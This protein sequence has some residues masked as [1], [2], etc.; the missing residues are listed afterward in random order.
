[1]NQ[2]TCLRS[3]NARQPV[4]VTVDALWLPS[5]Q[6]FAF[7]LF[8]LV[9]RY[10][11]GGNPNYT[12]DYLGPLSNC[13]DFSGSLPGLAE[14]LVYDFNNSQHIFSRKPLFI[15]STALLPL[16]LPDSSWYSSS[17]LL[18]EFIMQQTL[19]LVGR[20]QSVASVNTQQYLTPSV[21]QQSSSA[22]CQRQ[23]HFNMA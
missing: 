17:V 3:Q 14:N 11:S 18:L 16:P 13:T 7:R 15:T 20:Q 5:R 1:M 22:F 2:D 23:L 19:A 8:G 4:G 12:N 21:Q 10:G 6:M 9:C